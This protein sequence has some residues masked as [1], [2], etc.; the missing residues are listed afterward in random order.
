MIE[1]KRRW[2]QR[3]PDYR[4][5]NLIEKRL[6]E[7]LQKSLESKSRRTPGFATTWAAAEARYLAELR[8]Y[9]RVSAAVAAVAI[10]AVT[11]GLWP[12][13][14]TPDVTALARSDDFLTSTL[15]TAPSDVLIPKHDVDIY[16]EIPTLPESS[17][18]NEGALL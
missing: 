3:C 14:Q 15:W 17:D 1:Q 8:R 18:L 11:I 2:Q 7:R 10:I 6:G 12:S 13:E 9:R 5:N 16:Q 4:E